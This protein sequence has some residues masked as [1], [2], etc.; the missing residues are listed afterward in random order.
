MHFVSQDISRQALKEGEAQAQELGCHS[1]I[2]FSH[3]DFFS[4][5]TVSAKAYIIKSIFHDWSD[6]A[7]VRILKALLP[8]LKNGAHVLVGESLMPD[9]PALRATA[10]DYEAQR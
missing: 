4:P 2:S 3:H 10:W 1:R 6:E 7:C 9:P 8:V 5:Q